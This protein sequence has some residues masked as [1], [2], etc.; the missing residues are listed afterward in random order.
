MMDVLI[1]LKRYCAELSG[2]PEISPDDSASQRLPLFLSQI[3]DPARAI[4][5]GQAWLLFVVKGR[6]RPTPADIEK[7]AHLLAKQFGQSIAFVFPS[8]PAFDRNRL[9]KRRIPFIVPQRQLFM[10]GTMLDLREAHGSPF[11]SKLRQ[12]RMGVGPAVFENEHF[13]RSAGTGDLRFG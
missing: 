5:F 8:L 12:A 7:H 1:E 10:P 9:L 2:D 11:Q 6:E 13:A 3:Y 4:L